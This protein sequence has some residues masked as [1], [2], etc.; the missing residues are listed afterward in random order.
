MAAAWCGDQRRIA[1]KV[2]QRHASASLP[3]ALPVAAGKVP[4]EN[5]LS[6][7]PDSIT[8][9]ENRGRADGGDL[10]CEVPPKSDAGR[11]PDREVRRADLELE[12]GTGLPP[13]VR[14]GGGRKE[15]MG[16]AGP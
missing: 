3:S 7:V 10:E 4:P 5:H 9:T 6:D 16:D 12:E 14:R 2:H 8:K 11:Y 1:T 15:D 13:N